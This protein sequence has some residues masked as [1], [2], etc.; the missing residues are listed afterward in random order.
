MP[1]IGLPA[2]MMVTPPGVKVTLGRLPSE[3]V[4]LGFLLSRSKIA[5][6][7]SSLRTGASEAAV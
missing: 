3:A 4:V 1:P 7:E 6:V 5:L 2:A